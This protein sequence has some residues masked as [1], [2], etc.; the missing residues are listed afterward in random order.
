MKPQ[1]A[2]PLHS[3]RKG[4]FLALF[5]NEGRNNTDEKLPLLFADR[6]RLQVD[7]GLCAS[8]MGTRSHRSIVAEKRRIVY[9]NI[10]PKTRKT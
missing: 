2:Q 8:R 7:I 3:L 10:L 6:N 1:S 4:V 5:G 9:E